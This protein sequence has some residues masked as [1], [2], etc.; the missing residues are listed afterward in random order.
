MDSGNHRK[1]WLSIVTTIDIIDT[2]Q[3]SVTSQ[4]INKKCE[5]ITET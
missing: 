2:V 1:F 4:D 3:N 5:K